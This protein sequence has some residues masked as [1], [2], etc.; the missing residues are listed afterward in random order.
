MT[1]TTKN[2]LIGCLAAVAAAL[3]LGVSSCVGF[4]VWLYRPGQLLDPGKLVDADTTGYIEWTLRLDDPGCRKL[5]DQLVETGQ[6]AADVMRSP[7]PPGLRSWLAERQRQNNE[8]K[9]RELFPMVVAWTAR[10]GEAPGTDLQLLTV[11]IER[12]GNRVVLADWVLDHI[13]S[14][15]SEIKSIEHGDETIHQFPFA[16]GGSITFFI[17]GCNVFFAS[18][19]ETAARTVERLAQAGS[20]S[21]PRAELEALLDASPRKSALR[22]AILNDHGEVARTW[23]RLSKLLRRDTESGNE[24][25]ASDGPGERHDSRSRS[26]NQGRPIVGPSPHGPTSPSEQRTRREAE[27]AS[28]GLDEAAQAEVWTSARGATLWG[29]FDERG[30]LDVTVELRGSDADLARASAPAAEAAVRD[31]IARADIDA[32]LAA[33]TD[34]DRI[35]LHATMR[36]VPAAL[37]RLLP[38]RRLGRM[39]RWGD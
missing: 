5:F 7:L 14:W 24:G 30:T 27:E 34:G 18:D 29:G 31:L 3:V 4:V 1:S 16:R 38:R 2:V 8:R 32:D 20:P 36:D 25:G 13:L 26:S 33:T 6:R 21:P 39:R 17:R 28:G 23:D 37:T 10:S 19:V 22:G 12:L 15:N 9:L 35:R 11:S